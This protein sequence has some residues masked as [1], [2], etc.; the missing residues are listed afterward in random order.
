MDPAKL[1]VDVWKSQGGGYFCLSTKS[2]SGT[3]K[4]HY[5]E[6]PRLSEIKEFIHD[7][8]DHNLYFCPTVFDKPKRRKEYVK[9]SHFLWADLDDV[10]PRR[11]EPRPQIAWESSPKRYAALWRVNDT[12]DPKILEE[13]NRNLTYAIGADKA[14]WDLT[15]VLRI[16]GTRNYKYKG[17]PRGKLLWTADNALALDHFPEMGS[18]EGD[19]QEILRKIRRRIKRSTYNLLVSRR[20]T[21]GKRSEVIYRLERELY[22]QGVDKDDILVVIKSSVWNKFAGRRDEDDQLRRE[23]DKL[24]ERQ[25]KRMNGYHRDDEEMESHDEMVKQLSLIK[26]EEVDWIWYPYIPRGK[27]T[28]LEGDPDLGKSW[29]TMA[30]ASHITK[31]K[32]FPLTGHRIE[33]T[34]MMMSAED[35]LADTIRPRFDLLQADTS[36]IF[37]YDTAVTFDPDGADLVEEQIEKYKPTLVVIDPL[38]AYLG[39]SVDLHKA[40]ETR[41]VMARLAKLA[42]RQAVAVLAVRHLTKGSRDRAIYRGI[43]SIDLTAAARSIL[44]VGRDPDDEFGR[45]LCHIKSNLAPKGDSFKYELRREVKPPF[46]WGETTQLTPADLFKIEKAP[47]ASEYTA[48][49]DFLIDKLKK[50]PQP[51]ATVMRDAEARGISVKMLSR[52]AQDL[53]VKRSST[54]WKL[55]KA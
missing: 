27:V 44:L 47:S 43:G 13:V 33:G 34:V 30:I 45:V 32:R 1:I 35:G 36:R 14:G 24:P 2:K 23:L 16:P 7:Y 55:I 21:I 3:W 22:E 4:D 20:A 25:L 6:K 54:H 39:G 10:D 8:S 5:F 49:R 31:G 11:V 28:L 40:N 9:D 52:V 17:G 51:T 15:Q 38:V 29:L 50:E 26:P 12:H 48:A 42:E 18:S 46:R 41:E 37:C 19:A 53:G